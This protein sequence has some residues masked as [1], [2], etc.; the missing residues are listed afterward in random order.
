M[1]CTK[2][3]THCDLAY[4]SC[5]RC[6]AKNLACG[7]ERPQTL[8]AP[9]TS[10]QN[11]A[12]QIL[13]AVSDATS[14]LDSSSQT[15]SHNMVSDCTNPSSVVSSAELVSTESQGYGT[16]DLES[17]DTILGYTGNSVVQSASR[18][19]WSSPR[20][21]YLEP[22]SLMNSANLEINDL[23]FDQIIPRAPKAFWPRRV[24]ENQFSLNKSFLLCTLRSYPSMLLPGDTLPPFIHPQGWIDKSGNHRVNHMSLLGPLA[25]CVAIVQMFSVKNESN[26]KFLW[27]TIRTE[28]EKLSAE[29]R[30]S[31][32]KY[33]YHY[34]GDDLNFYSVRNTISGMP[35]LL[36]KQ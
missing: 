25:T 16:W 24:R 13:D 20:Q 29:V 7:Y 8:K 6:T 11:S 22:S 15:A 28:Q 4:P 18:D 9:V 35:W 5:S 19:A 36:F 1:I 30:Q 31:S 23:M 33:T 21:P 12:D 2:A 17:M 27:K 3:K 32:L 14:L 26:V 10:P 34:E